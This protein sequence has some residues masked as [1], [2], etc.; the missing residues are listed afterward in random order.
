MEKVVLRCRFLD[1]HNADLTTVYDVSEYVKD[2]PGGQDALLEVAGQDAT[3]AYEDVG[4]SEDAREILHTYLVGALEG[5]KEEDDSPK[6]QGSSVPQG[7]QV[8]KRSDDHQSKHSPILTPARLEL[9]GAGI[10]TAGLVWT[11]NRYHVL[12]RFHRGHGSFTQGFVLA[13]ITAGVL[14][15]LGSYSLE[16]IIS[17]PGFQSYPSRIPGAVKRRSS[18]HPAG[19]LNPQEYMH[20]KLARKQELANG[21]WRFVFDLPTKWSVL[22][23]PIGQHVAIKATIDEHTV[24]R[25]YTPVS[26]NRDLGRM[27]LLVRVYPDGQMGNYLKNLSVGDTADI[28][29]PKGAMRYRKGGITSIGMVAGGTGITPMYQIIRAICEDKSD[30]TQ[31][32][33]VY[34]NRSE[35]DIMLREKLDHFAQTCPNKFK[36][37]YVL[38]EPPEG[39][40]G[41]KGRVTKDVLKERL[42]NA[43]KDTQM[44]LCGPPGMVNAMKQNL[45][46][47]GCDE[48]GAVSKMSDQVFCF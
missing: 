42:P 45:V 5:A 22:G 44:M 39:F 11:L 33:L 48:P 18:F 2:H 41:G 7:V 38:D 12:D 47:L 8:I 9:A 43:S 21:I 34:A 25:S 36:V 6:Q 40:K 46:E 19:V 26:N 3:A 14:A 15:V 17:T 20:L 28:R 37:H 23:L 16:R 31:V 4:H 35:A 10:A 29:G 32:S 1:A 24:V 13:T 30:D 27:E